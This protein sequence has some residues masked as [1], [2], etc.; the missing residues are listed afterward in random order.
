MILKEIKCPY[1]N[2]KIRTSNENAGQCVFCGKSFSDKEGNVREKRFKEPGCPNCGG[3]VRFSPKLQ[4]FVCSHC[5][6]KFEFE[7]KTVGEKDDFASDYVV[8]FQKCEEDYVPKMVEALSKLPYIPDDIFEN[9]TLYPAKSVYLPYYLYDGTYKADYSCSIG[10]DRTVTYYKD[11]IKKERTVTDWSPF[12]GN[13]TGSFWVLASASDSL[14][15]K[16]KSATEKNFLECLTDE[17]LMKDYS[18]LYMAGCAVEPYAYA[19][20]KAYEERGKNQV[21]EIIENEIATSLPGDKVVSYFI[22]NICILI[23]AFFLGRGMEKY[24][25]EESRNKRTEQAKKFMENYTNKLK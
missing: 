18:P 22:W 23:G 11:G 25:L 20:E 15:T 14:K 5:E 2:A 7:P 10:Y 1:C 4:Q 21:S 13:K 17:S 16:F 3:E 12:S 9:L 8:P 24:I 6:S 19:M